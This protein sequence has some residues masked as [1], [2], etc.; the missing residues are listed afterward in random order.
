MKSKRIYFLRTA[1]YDYLL[2]GKN[3]Y[4][5]FNMVAQGDVGVVLRPGAKKTFLSSVPAETLKVQ[6]VFSSPRNSLPLTAK[7]ISKKPI[8]LDELVE[9]GYKMEDFIT[10]GEFFKAGI[11]NVNL[12]RTRFVDALIANQLQEDYS[13]IFERIDHLLKIIGQD[14]SQ[15]IAVITHGF[16]LKV[17]ESYAHSS[18]VKTDPTLIKKYFSGDTEG[19]KF[20]EGFIAELSADRLKFV[21]YIGSSKL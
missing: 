14:D 19:F 2:Q 3:L 1:P 11:P 15:D 13:H 21:S 7:F 5:S 6:S 16:I 12:A 4:E 17:I 20:C 18:K 10:Q 9:I 8:L